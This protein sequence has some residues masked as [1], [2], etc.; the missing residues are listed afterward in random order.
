MT[1]EKYTRKMFLNDMLALEL[2]DDQRDCAEKWLASLEK[3]A[4][5]P[6]VNKTRIA[7]EALATDVVAAMVAHA[8]EPI[9]A[10][11]ISEH[12][13]GITTASKAVAVVKVA[14]ERGELEKYQ[15]KGRT[16]YRLTR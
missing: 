1:N 6:R 9:N 3:K 13:A 4:A 16:Y 2:T 5:A 15:E 7:N 14:I 10:K 12:V 8:D 11:W